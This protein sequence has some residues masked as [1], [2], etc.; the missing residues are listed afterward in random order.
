MVQERFID[1]NKIRLTA[2]ASKDESG[3]VLV[4]LRDVIKAIEQTPTADVVP[5]SEIPEYIPLDNDHALMRVFEHYKKT[6]A[7]EMI[8][9]LLTVIE[10][11]RQQY[12]LVAHEAP[13]YGYDHHELKGVE[14]G[15]RHAISTIKEVKGK[16]TEE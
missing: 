6:V 4:S 14:R 11:M 16:Y 2:T 7:K 15:L 3:E 5:R 12:A 9:E 8:D 1:A 10:A 13:H